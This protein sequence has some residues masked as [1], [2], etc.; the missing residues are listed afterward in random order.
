M[1][2]FEV[3]LRLSAK[4]LTEVLSEYTEHF[5]GCV[6]IKDNDKD[7]DK[8]QHY[9]HGKRKKDIG[10]REL[11]LLQLSDH[12]PHSLEQLQKAMVEHEFAASSIHPQLSQMVRAQ[13]IKRLGDGYYMLNTA[14]SQTALN[15]PG[16]GV[17]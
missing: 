13:E 2:Y 15:L 10:G 7:N 8:R 11:I 17:G 6:E 9:A 1:K 16:H 4:T 12:K 3:K 14:T 5:I